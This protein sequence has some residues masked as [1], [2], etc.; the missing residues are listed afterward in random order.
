[1]VVCAPVRTTNE[2]QEPTCTTLQ[3]SKGMRLGGKKKKKE[4]QKR[5]SAGGK[6]YPDS[7]IH[8]HKGFKVLSS[9]AVVDQTLGTSEYK[10]YFFASI[11]FSSKI[12][13]LFILDTENNCS[14]GIKGMSEVIRHEKNV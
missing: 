14:M 10:T 7:L 9:L 4:K 3:A 13:K 8:K 6:R 5:K 1:M 11:F 2:E 12:A